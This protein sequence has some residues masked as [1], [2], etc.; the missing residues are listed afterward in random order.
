MVQPVILLVVYIVSK[1]GDA[2]QDPQN[3]TDVHG[4]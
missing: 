3:D 4:K 1:N 2:Y